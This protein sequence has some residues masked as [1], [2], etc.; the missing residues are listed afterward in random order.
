MDAQ[1]QAVI[2]WLDN[3]GGWGLGRMQIDFSIT[4]LTA[5]AQTP[6]LAFTPTEDWYAVECDQGPMPVPTDGALEGETG[7]ACESDGDC[8]LI[9][10]H[11]PSQRLYEMWRAD[12]RNGVFNGGCLAIWNYA[13]A[14]PATGRGQDCTSADAAGL[15]IAPL[16]F[17]VEEVA[18]GN[19]NHALR[20]ILPNARIRHRTYVHPATH[21]TNAASGGEDAPPY[22]VRL[23]LRADFPLA[24]LPNDGAR[25]VAR[26]MQRYGIILADG[27][28][29][30]LTA[31]S[32]RGSALRWEDVLGSRDLDTVQVSDFQMVEAGTR[33]T[34]TGDCVRNP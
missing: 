24:S 3:A 19:I 26:A 15:P 14:P 2:T 28:N 22:G 13:T 25:T 30:A 16:L 23:R 20:F 18:S 17:T 27:G 29:V 8:H 7:Y 34:W 5:N 9:V 12:I 10:D 21:A 31:R 1:S 6:L 11:P 4:V 33:H 32:D